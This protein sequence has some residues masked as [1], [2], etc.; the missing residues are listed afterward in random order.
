[1]AYMNDLKTYLGRRK[2]QLTADF[3]EWRDHARDLR[4]FIDPWSGRDLDDTDS[5]QETSGRKRQQY[6]YDPAATVAHKSLGG[7]LFSHLTPPSRPWFDIELPNSDVMQMRPVKLWLDDS[8]ERL[9]DVFSKSNLYQAFRMGMDELPLFGTWAAAIEEDEENVIHVA[10]YTFGEYRIAQSDRGRVDTFY[11]RFSVTV[12]QL[13]QWFGIE[14]VPKTLRNAFY[15]GNRE[16]LVKVC[17]LV[18][19]NDDKTVEIKDAN[20]FPFRS[21]YWVESDTFILE[22]RGFHE[23]PIVAPRWATNG[24]RV[25]GNSPCMTALPDVK[26]LQLIAKDILTLSGKMANP[27]MLSNGIKP[28]DIDT[29]ENGVSRANG[30]SQSLTP[31]YQIQ[32]QAI[33]V[34]NDKAS[35]IHASINRELYVDLFRLMVDSDRREM[36]AR[37]VS[38]REAEKMMLLGPVVEGLS[39]ELLSPLIVRTFN[40]MLRRGLIDVPP[41][42]IQGMPLN[43]RFSSPLAQAQRAAGLNALERFLGFA[44][45]VISLRPEAADKIDVDEILETGANGYGINQRSLREDADVQE[46]RQQRAQAAAQERSVAMESQAASGAKDMADAMAIREASQGGI[47]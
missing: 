3:E 27:P 20:G 1:M 30:G 31:L 22:T 37:E 40:I 4:D 14:G 25:Y 44:G 36:T 29:A 39:Q 24:N 33:A 32:A 28:G 19:P 5:R 10:P 16:Q 45:G 34:L 15:N 12:R 13:V 47:F 42:E 38:A 7:A 11:R 2:T 6:I 17:H 26:R 23:F 43:I 9:R 18:E 35:R 8:E 41:E 46:I 21:I